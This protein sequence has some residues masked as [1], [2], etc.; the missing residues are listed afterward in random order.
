M[1]FSNLIIISRT[2]YIQ[3]TSTHTLTHSHTYHYTKHINK[4]L[5]CTNHPIKLYN[6]HPHVT[7]YSKES[8]VHSMV[9]HPIERA[10][11]PNSQENTQAKSKLYNQSNSRWIHN[12]LSS[13]NLI[14]IHM[15]NP[16]VT[17][18]HLFKLTYT[19]LPTC[20]RDR[21]MHAKPFSQWSASWS[22]PMFTKWLI[23]PPSKQSL[24][25]PHYA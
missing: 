19:C 16:T 6:K 24:R 14:Y 9:G 25:R 7:A 13:H 15:I 2:P 3:I 4:I 22:S 11:I 17:P 21:H 8:C 10:V 1:K 20:C 12:T 18:L 5:G 23:R